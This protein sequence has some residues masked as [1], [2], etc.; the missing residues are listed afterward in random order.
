[1]GSA[2]LTV[3]TPLPPFS[4]VKRIKHFSGPVCAKTATVSTD[5]SEKVLESGSRQSPV[6]SARE[7]C[8][9]DYME[10]IFSSLRFK[11][12]YYCERAHW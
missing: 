10:Q 3:P 5:K 2:V 9:L 11:N 4:S 7:N 1:M 6:S 12:C 8:S